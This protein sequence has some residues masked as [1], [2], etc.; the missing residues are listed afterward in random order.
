[1]IYCD[2]LMTKMQSDRIL[3]F[4][5]MM[6]PLLCFKL[7]LSSFCC[8]VPDMNLIAS[9]RTSRRILA[10]TPPSIQEIECGSPIDSS[11]QTGEAGQ[12]AMNQTG[13]AGQSA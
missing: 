13:E 6:S 12:S 1:M 9:S 4:I 8:H 5:V 11:N 3:R 7:L 10:K 2:L